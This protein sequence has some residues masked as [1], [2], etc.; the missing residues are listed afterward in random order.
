MAYSSSSAGYEGNFGGHY[1]VNAVTDI[2]SQNEEANYTVVRFYGFMTKTGSVGVY[3]FDPTYCNIQPTGGM[4]NG[5]VNGYDGRNGSGPWYGI[6]IDRGFYHNNDGSLQ[7]GHYFYHNASNMPYIGTGAT[8]HNLWLPQYYRYAELSAFSWGTITDVSIQINVSSNRLADYVQFSV[9]NGGSYP[10]G[11]G[12][13][14][15]SKTV[16][17]GSPSTPLRSGTTY[18]VKVQV[19]R[20]ASGLWSTSGTYTIT[21]KRQNNFFDLSDF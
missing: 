16:T 1:R 5:N 21:T 15:W 20:K 14:W 13:D 3:N 8:S 10:Y 18:N 9:D 4:V 2:V 7:I 11:F 17:L 19:R 12:G 6:T